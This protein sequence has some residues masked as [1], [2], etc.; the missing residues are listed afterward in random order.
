MSLNDIPPELLGHILC[1]LDSQ[2]LAN[3]ARTRASFTDVARRYLYRMLYM[4]IGPATVHTIQL[5]HQRPD[6]AQSVQKLKLDYHFNPHDPEHP[7]DPDL[8]C[9]LLQTDDDS[10]PDAN[11]SRT[12]PPEPF[13]TAALSDLIST[14]PN[15]HHLLL[16][17]IH[18]NPAPWK[19]LP[20]LALPRS[21]TTITID[22]PHPNPLMPSIANHS[23]Q[24]LCFLPA[25]AVQ[26]S[27]RAAI[28]P[29]T[30]LDDFCSLRRLVVHASS[31]ALDRCFLARRCFGRLSV[32]LPETLEEVR[33]TDGACKT[34][35]V[36]GA[37]TRMV[38]EKADNVP[39]LKLLVLEEVEGH[40]SEGEPWW[41][42][43][44]AGKEMGSGVV[45]LNCGM[46]R[47]R[48]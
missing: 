24:T 21:I 42:L 25:A 41:Y 36:V 38:R 45:V 33:V 16:T 18:G 10:D 35:T 34:G 23:L 17:N 15:V 48:S 40:L 13:T 30:P 19:P 46:L 9:L 3:V 7:S 37:W 44:L 12:N 32:L 43:M 5:I 29:L 14:F 8:A 22:T 28:S 20:P 27:P 4:R 47:R 26:S 2:E 6:L 31:L 11:A 39:G 1:H